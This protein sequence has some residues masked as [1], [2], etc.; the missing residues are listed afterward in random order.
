MQYQGKL[1]L[2]LIVVD[3]AYGLNIRVIVGKEEKCHYDN[4]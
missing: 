4:R 2:Y 1:H 3:L